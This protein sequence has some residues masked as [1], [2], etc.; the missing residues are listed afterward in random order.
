M[1]GHY[2]DVD[3]PDTMAVWFSE[4]CFARESEHIVLGT[5]RDGSPIHSLN[6]GISAQRSLV[7]PAPTDA[8]IDA[9]EQTQRL[10]CVR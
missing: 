10:E 8:P 5:M 3:D 9:L 1:S 7:L 2:F 4:D 6:G